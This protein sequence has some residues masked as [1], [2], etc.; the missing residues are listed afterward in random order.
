MFLYF[1][2][3]E[4]I[5]EAKPTVFQVAPHEIFSIDGGRLKVFLRD[6]FLDPSGHSGFG[7]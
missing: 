1:M 4:R 7:H 5:L 2:L 3:I 6:G